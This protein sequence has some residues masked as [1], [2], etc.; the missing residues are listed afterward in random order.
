[1]RVSL[2]VVLTLLCTGTLAG[3]GV[4]QPPA[5]SETLSTEG[6]AHDAPP[7]LPPPRDAE[8][9]EM[10]EQVLVSRL[11]RRLDLDD[12]QSVILMRRF[13]ELREQQQSL[14]RKRMEILHELRGVL[15]L[16]EDEAALKRLMSDLREVDAR[17]VAGEQDARKSFQDMDLSIWQQAKLELFLSEVEGDMRR[18]GPHGRG[19]RPMP[20]GMDM[21]RPRPGRGPDET[22][23]GRS[24]SMRPEERQ[25]PRRPRMP[26]MP[27]PPKRPEVEFE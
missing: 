5:S 8:S 26:E 3:T 12:E 22:F 10:L 2:I 27:T 15:R 21:R 16:E 9:R 1:M 24:R 11:S 18:P 13:S 20:P 14:H 19:G 25:A 7:P 4:A 6:E 17:I 23:D